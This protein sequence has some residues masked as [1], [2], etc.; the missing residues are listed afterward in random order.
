MGVVLKESYKN[1]LTLFIAIAIGAVNTLFLYVYYLDAS[2]YGLISFLLSTSLILKP[3]VSLGTNNAIV[4]FFSTYETIEQKDRF[5]SSV[6][7]IPLVALI[8]L[9]VVGAYFQDEISSQFFGKS[10]LTQKYGHLIYWVTIAITYFDIF[11]A[12]AR[13]HLK[14]VFGNIL[15]ELFVRVVI[16]VLLIL[17]GLEWINE[18]QFVYAI[19]GA[20]YVQMFVIMMFALKCYLPKLV[21]KFPDNFKEVAQYCMYILLAGS[22]ASILLDIDKFMI[23]QHEEAIEQVA[24]YGVAVY[25]GTVIEIPGRAMMQIIQPLTAKA[26]NENNNALVLDLYKKTS[27]NLL[28]TSGAIFILVI[29]NINSLYQLMPEKYTG[30]FWI[31][32]MIAFSKL[33]HMFLGNNGT[34]ISNSKHYKVLLP[35][36]VSMAIAVIVLNRWLIAALGINGAALSTV[37]VILIFNTVKLLYVK[38]KFK[39][40]PTTSKTW[41]TLCFILLITT[42]GYFID[43]K[44]H[45]VLNIL[46][47]SFLIL[48]I[49]IFLV[50][51]FQLSENISQLFHQLLSKF[52]FSDF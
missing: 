47:E 4:K 16:F 34:I 28:I 12:W 7:W 2:Y 15:K 22:A 21:F 48:L 50:L 20:Y 19:V 40:H 36:G 49:Y 32:I 8:P 3:L 33:Y 38:R 45:P 10:K 6:L 23:P 29:S 41:I 51:K 31:V 24:Y 30:G 52:K 5:L 35:Y 43:F 14:S 37:I 13:V 42:A 11:Y 27:I 46:L 17:S 25:I 1:T 44:W 39:M 26:L 9:G 18:E